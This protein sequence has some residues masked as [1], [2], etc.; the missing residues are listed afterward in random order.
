[1]AKSEASLFQ[2]HLQEKKIWAVQFVNCTALSEATLWQ[3][4][5]QEK[6]I[7]AVQ[8]TNC[9]ALSD[10]SLFQSHLQEKKIWA[11]H[12]PPFQVQ[13]SDIQMIHTKMAPFSKCFSLF[14]RLR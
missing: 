4:H 13:F 6:K 5:L 10:A 12:A 3:S 1:M 2:S 9:T 14:I 11:V 8:F 7:W